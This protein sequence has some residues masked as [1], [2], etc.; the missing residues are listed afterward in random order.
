MM[1]MTGRHGERVKM[2]VSTHAS[3]P[4]QSD[5]PEDEPAPPTAMALKMIQKTTLSDTT[6]ARRHAIYNK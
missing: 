3:R 4:Y 6:S 5:C 2:L 1:G